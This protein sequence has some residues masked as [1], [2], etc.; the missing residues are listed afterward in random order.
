MF[1]EQ[2]ASLGTEAPEERNIILSPINGLEN[3]FSDVG[4]KHSVPTAL[5]E[6]L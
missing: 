5:K 2:Q 6:E 1:I 3:Q 4:Y